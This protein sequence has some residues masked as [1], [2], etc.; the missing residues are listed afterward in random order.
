[1][2][3]YTV[4]RAFWWKGLLRKV[5]ETVIMA[6]AQAK[7]LVGVVSPTA[8]IVAAPAP[9]RVS[10]RA[11]PLNVAVAEVPANGDGTN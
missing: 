1:M 5:G 8:A 6:E 11:T 10:R 3:N 7:Y 4:N 9:K 2:P